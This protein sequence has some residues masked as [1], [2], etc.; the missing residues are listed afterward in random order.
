MKPR[1]LSDWLALPLIELVR[2]YQITLSPWLGR[3][4]RFEPTCS[5]YS[6]TALKRFGALRG[7]VLTVKR[8]ARCHPWGSSGYDPVPEND[9]ARGA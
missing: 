6:L 3:S 7:T 4:C 8:L 9:D 2:L 1:R 5:D